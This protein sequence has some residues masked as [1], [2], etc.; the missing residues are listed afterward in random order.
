MWRTMIDGIIKGTGDSRYLKGAG[1]PTTYAEFK[2]IAEAGTLPFDLNG[3]NEAGWQ[4]LATALNKANLFSDTTAA[5]YPSCTTPDAALSLLGRLN[6][7]LGNDYVWKKY[8]GNYTFVNGTQEDGTYDGTLTVLYSSSVSVNANHEIA[9]DAPVSTGTL[10]SVKSTLP[11]KYVKLGSETSPVYY[12]V[13]SNGSSSVGV[14]YRSVSFVYSESNISYVNSP[15]SN[16]YPPSVSDGYTYTALGQIG[17]KANITSFSY[18]GTGGDKTITMPFPIKCAIVQTLPSSGGDKGTH[19]FMVAIQWQN[20]VWTSTYGSSSPE[21]VTW[22]E[23]S[24]TINSKNA[25]GTTYFVVVF[26]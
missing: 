26:G 9:L 19:S 7:G 20:Y 16:A 15:T 21:T 23:N 4:Q 24:F 1:W 12:F 8:I 6:A 5:K 22:T 3:I 25:S 17:N 18:V 11:G 14:T 10:S 13:T 2:A